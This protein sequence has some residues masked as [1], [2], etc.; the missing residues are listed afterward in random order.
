MKDWKT[1]ADQRRWKETWK[2]NT[3]WYFELAPGPEEDT[4]RETSEIL[5]FN[6]S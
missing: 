1:V 5:Q 3:I 4:G 6:K 2:Q